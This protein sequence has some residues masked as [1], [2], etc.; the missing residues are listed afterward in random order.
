MNKP[1]QVN[2]WNELLQAPRK[3]EIRKQYPHPHEYHCWGCDYIGPMTNDNEH[4]LEG[5]QALY[6]DG[7][8][9]KGRH[10]LAP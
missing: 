4:T 10:K 9:A 8:I 3:D 7:C 2:D 5:E 6:C 1:I